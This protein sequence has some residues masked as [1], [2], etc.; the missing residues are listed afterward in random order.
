MSRSR[1]LL[2]L[3]LLSLI[4]AAVFTIANP[5][6]KQARSFTYT[7][8]S[9]DGTKLTKLFEGRR[10][11]SAQVAYYARYSK[12]FGKIS[13][14]KP[15]A[16]CG[17]PASA[18]NVEL[19]W[20]DRFHQLTNWSVQAQRDCLNG[21]GFSSSDCAGGSCIQYYCYSSGSGC[22]NTQGSCCNNTTSC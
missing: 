13:Q 12:N 21:T 7:L 19:T 17:V 20:E 15:S 16:G 10:P 11:T 5:K 2:F 14:S 3:S 4:V 6:Q 22:W 1:I 9:S 18:R 8:T